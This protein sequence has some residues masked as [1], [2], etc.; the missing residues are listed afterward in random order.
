MSKC[1]ARAL[2][3]I[4]LSRQWPQGGSS[5]LGLRSQAVSTA[6]LKWLSRRAYTSS[7]TTESVEPLPIAD[8]DPNT[9]SPSDEASTVV[10]PN[11]GLQP[12][13]QSEATSQPE[14]S[15]LDF[16]V[17]LYQRL[18]QYAV[19]P[20]LEA[21]KRKAGDAPSDE[22]FHWIATLTVEELDISASGQGSKR[23][24]A[25]EDA[26]RQLARLLSLPESR[27]KLDS[28]L[29]YTLNRATAKETIQRYCS[30]MRAG[31]DREINITK[32]KA[33]I[34]HTV[35]LSTKA[36]QP[37]GKPITAASR[38]AAATIAELSCAQQIIT[39][40]PDAYPT[41]FGNP[42]TPAIVL[43][44]NHVSAL[45]NIVYGV[46]AYIGPRNGP[47]VNGESYI[48][49]C[50]AGMPFPPSIARILA[51]GAITNCLDPAIIYAALEQLPPSFNDEVRPR[52]DLWRSTSAW[53][54]DHYCYHLIMAK[55]RS[56][57]SPDP[58]RREKV[59]KGFDPSFQDLEIIRSI[60]TAAQSIEQ[61][62]LATGLANFKVATRDFYRPFRTWPLSLR[63]GPYGNQYNS[64]ISRNAIIRHLLAFGLGKNIAQIQPT[65]LM[66]PRMHIQDKSYAM[67][68]KMDT[69]YVQAAQQRH[70]GFRPLGHM[71]NACVEQVGP[72]VLFSG[73]LGAPSET[74]D[75]FQ[76]EDETPTHP[77]SARYFT[78][79]PTMEA[80]LYSHTASIPSEARGGQ[81]VEV[82]ESPDY[83]QLVINDWLPVLVKST[84]PG[85]SHDEARNLLLQARDSLRMAYN[86]AMLDYFKSFKQSKGFYYTLL[87]L[88][89]L[90]IDEK[91]R[92]RM[93]SYFGKT[94]R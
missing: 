27:T 71:L 56:M 76:D 54:G 52:S 40:H 43:S 55:L 24:L 10:D 31:G 64:N 77:I 20:K 5:R 25:E 11:Q 9:Q 84:D 21:T 12:Q 88:S 93:T 90:S 26:A 16:L 34:S 48:D 8:P 1:G 7:S 18:A 33:D 94:R 38:T 78:A 37:F 68:M 41:K 79:L 74:T 82:D 45:L 86:T 6:P 14:H 72:L 69:Q 62:L 4:R 28:M 91:L 65:C 30:L 39:G 67:D 50:L 83:S 57:L 44:A 92:P 32:N 19:I 13:E 75:I 89:K 36:G 22:S 73:Q 23:I 42:F 15:K 58:Q 3:S 59:P 70:V 81:G 53:E 29:R 80:I 49:T 47:L 85:M 51:M 2:S 17:H 66:P 63:Y 60:D 61:H 87:S 35:Q 46:Q